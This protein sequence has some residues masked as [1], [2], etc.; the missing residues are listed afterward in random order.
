M[1]SLSSSILINMA[2]SGNRHHGIPWYTPKRTICLYIIWIY[3]YIIYTYYY[4]IYIYISI[5]NMVIHPWFFGR[6]VD[7]GAELQLIG[8]SRG[9]GLARRLPLRRAGDGGWSIISIGIY[10]IYNDLCIFMEYKSSITFITFM[11][12]WSIRIHNIHDV[13]ILIVKWNNMDDHTTIKACD[14][15]DGTS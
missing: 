2:M 10:K 9:D 8:W 11:V 7:P 1:I 6:T 4:M 15:F 14:I 5:G 3:I 13:W 12:L